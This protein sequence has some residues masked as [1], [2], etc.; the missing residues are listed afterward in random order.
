PDIQ[1]ELAQFNQATPM[2]MGE[3]RQ[4]VEAGET[5]FAYNEGGREMRGLLIAVVVFSYSRTNAGM[6]DM[7]ALN[8]FAL[9]GFLATAPNGK[10]N[11]AFMDALRTSFLMNPEWERRI[12]G[13]NAAIAKTAMEGAR[14]R[15]QI[16]SQTNED[17]SRLE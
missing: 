4:W 2:P 17:I 1:K 10:L 9:P 7:I 5:L 6:G 16:I 13:H 12:A 15:S 8:A 11:F 14:K 3:L